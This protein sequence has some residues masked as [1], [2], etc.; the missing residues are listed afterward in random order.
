MQT[1]KYKYKYDI[2]NTKTSKKR[3]TSKYEYNSIKQ[4]DCL[5]TENMKLI[6]N[7]RERRE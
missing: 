3:Y 5:I 1:N 4:L 7:R 2:E 6:F